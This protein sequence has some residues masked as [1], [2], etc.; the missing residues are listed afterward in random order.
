MA[1][2]LYSRRAIDPVKRQLMESPRDEQK[3]PFLGETD[4]ERLSFRQRKAGYS[5][6]LCL[7]LVLLSIVAH[8]IL[9][10]LWMKFGAFSKSNTSILYS[11]QAV[12]IS[13]YKTY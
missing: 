8:A 13:R 1:L 7:G 10:T 4:N 5:Q 11:K 6:Y 9:F 2:R 12:Q 3:E